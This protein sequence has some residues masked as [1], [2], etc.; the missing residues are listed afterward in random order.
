[1]DGD[2]LNWF[3]AG[4]GTQTLEIQKT[5]IVDTSM[6]CPPY[7]FNAFRSVNQKVNV[8]PIVIKTAICF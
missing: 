7:G 5:E 2:Y 6:L 4:S 1:L 8:S 3:A